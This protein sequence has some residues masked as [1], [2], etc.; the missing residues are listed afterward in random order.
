MR[1]DRVARRVAL[2]VLLVGAALA[3]A[4]VPPAVA[5]PFTFTNADDFTIFDETALASPVTVPGGTCLS[6]VNDVNVAVRWDHTRNVELVFQLRTPAGQLLTLLDDE[7]G[8]TQ[9]GDVLFDDEAVA[10]EEDL[11][12]QRPVGWLRPQEP[13]SAADGLESSGTWDLIVT[14]QAPQDTGVLTGWSL[15]F[16]CLDPVSDL[17]NVALPNPPV[18]IPDQSSA[19]LSVDVADCPSV[20]DVDVETVLQ[21]TQVN[22]LVLILQHA[23]RSVLLWDS[24]TSA[25]RG[26]WL[27]FD[28]EA[29]FPAQTVGVDPET[30]DPWPVGFFQVTPDEPLAAFDGAPGDGTWTFTV[31]D[32]RP[33][34]AGELQQFGLRVECGGVP[35]P[36]PGGGDPVIRLFGAGRVQTAVSVS[37]ESFPDPQTASVAVLATEGNFADALAGTPLAV[38]ANGPMLLTPVD[39]LV[40]DTADELARVLPGGATVY[41]LGGQAALSGA[42]E[43]AVADLGFTPERLAGASRYDTA[44]AIAA[45]VD[46]VQPISALVVADG[47]AFQAALVGGAAAP[48]LGAALLLSNGASPH[49]ATDAVLGDR[50]LDARTVGAVAV[51]AYPDLQT[52]SAAAEPAAMSV[53]V[54]QALDTAVGA[55]PGT[56]GVAN[57]VTFPDGLTGG[58]NIGAQGGPLL[59]TA[60]QQLSP[61]VGTYLTDNAP[62]IGLAYLYGGDAAIAPAVRDAITTAI[63]APPP[64]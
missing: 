29:A 40:T 7:G 43:Q 1:A 46:T 59:L 12:S 37:Q 3:G 24:Q 2:V 54:A 25:G 55:P 56:V 30:D 47:N 23:D 27:R 52:L 63:S 58:V 41:L 53:Q 16:N 36:P 62:S 4:P 64:R 8:S 44:A 9:G 26:V 5:S 6:P 19:A 15:R 60:Q 17:P 32:N 48:R 21:H 49:P 31:V 51:Q 42:V 38:V 61:E 35:P 28:D 45:E 13:L 20:T 11:Q 33:A 18:P 22:D 50:G 39:Q 14:D 34:D 10:S 57:L